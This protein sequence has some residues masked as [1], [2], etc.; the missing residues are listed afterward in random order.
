MANT[1]APFGLKQ[2]GLNGSPVTNFAVETRKAA[3][4]NDNNTPIFCNDLIKQLDTG[5]WFQWTNGTAV[6]QAVGV[7]FGCKYFSISQNTIVRQRFWPGADA[8][9]DVDIFY[10]PGILSPSAKFVI[11]S[12]PAGLTQADIGANFDIVVGSGSTST[13]FS[14]SYLSTAATGATLP[15]KLV[16]LWANYMGGQVGPGTEAGAYNWGVVALNTDQA[17]G[18]A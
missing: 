4:D 1:N 7:M 8:A 16:D 5:Y 2:L 11:Q 14:G 6:S 18:L 12:G 13:G 17:T 9:G 10:I 15:F 3:V